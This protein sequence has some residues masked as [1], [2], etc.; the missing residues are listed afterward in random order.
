MPFETSNARGERKSKSGSRGQKQYGTM[1]VGVLN[2][3]IATVH[4]STS[5]A[6]CGFVTSLPFR[7]WLAAPTLAVEKR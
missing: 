3:M 6:G 1:S 2:E 5:A 4:Y 7:L